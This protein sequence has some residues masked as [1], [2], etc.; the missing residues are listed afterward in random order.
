MSRAHTVVCPACHAAVPRSE[1]TAYKPFDRQ[2]DECD[3]YFE[4]AQPSSRFC[5]TA[6]KNKSYNYR[7]RTSS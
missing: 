2:C 4:S 6:C 1:L 3:E 7:R 5:T